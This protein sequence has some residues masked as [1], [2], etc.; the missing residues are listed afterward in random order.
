MVT[1]G[2][3]G[4]QVIT[5]LVSYI[6]FSHTSWDSVPGN[7]GSKGVPVAMKAVHLLQAANLD[8]SSECETS[9]HHL[10]CQQLES[11]AS[12]VDILTTELFAIMLTNNDTNPD[13]HSKLWNSCLEV[14]RDKGQ[15]YH[16]LNGTTTVDDMQ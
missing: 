2:V 13:S 15:V 9:V 1:V 3:G 8:L 11:N 7:P 14:Q 16:S 5:G 6:T 4:T 12:Q 10:A